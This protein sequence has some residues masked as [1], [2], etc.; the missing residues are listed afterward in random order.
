[1]EKGNETAQSGQPSVAAVEGQP[2]SPATGVGAQPAPTN[3]Q[4]STGQP[5]T[6]Q[7]AGGGGGSQADQSGPTRERD[8]WAGAPEVGETTLPDGTKLRRDAEGNMHRTDAS[9][10]EHIWHDGSWVSEG[11]R[12]PTSGSDGWGDPAS[13]WR[14]AWTGESWPESWKDVPRSGSTRVPGGSLGRDDAG[15]YTFGADTGGP[16]FSWNEQSGKWYDAS[17]GHPAPDG[18]AP[19]DPVE[20]WLRGAEADATRRANAP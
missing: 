3:G 19:P 15:A 5:Q 6:A 10:E 20:G 17:T 14:E 12:K 18:V 4:S 16:V 7:P 1:M 13:D 9:G 11:T 8:P 2:S